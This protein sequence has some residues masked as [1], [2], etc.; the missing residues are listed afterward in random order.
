MMRTPLLAGL[1]CALTLPAAAEHRQSTTTIGYCCK[2]TTSLT[3]CTFAKPGMEDFSLTGHSPRID[4]VWIGQPSYNFGRNTAVGPLI[5]TAEAKTDPDLATALKEYIQELLGYKKPAKKAAPKDVAITAPSG[6]G[7]G[8]AS[9]VI[10]A[11]TGDLSGFLEQRSTWGT[12][13]AKDVTAPLAA[14]APAKLPVT[15]ATPATAKA[16]APIV[17]EAEARPLLEVNEPARAD[18][19][20]AMAALLKERATWG[21]SPNMAKAASSTTESSGGGVSNLT[22]AVT[23]KLS[24]FLALRSTWGTGTAKKVAAPLAAGATAKFPKAEARAAKTTAPDPIVHEAE[25]RPLPQVNEPARAD[26]DKAMAALLKERAT[27]GTSPTT[28]IAAPS[29]SSSAGEISAV[30]TGDLAALLKQRESWGTGSNAAPTASAQANAPTNLTLLLGAASLGDYLS[31][32]DS[33]G[34]GPAAKAVA[35]PLAAGAPKSIALSSKGLSKAGP[36][37][38]TIVHPFV[39]SQP[40][41]LQQV[42]QA[43]LVR[44]RNSLFKERDSW[45]TKPSLSGFKAA[46]NLADYLKRRDRWGTGPKAKVVRAPLANGARKKLR[47]AKSKV[48]ASDSKPPIVHNFASRPLPVVGAIAPEKIKSALAG[49]FTERDSWGTEPVESAPRFAG[50]LKRY[51][52]RRE[53]WG[54]GP[55]AKVVKA[56]LANGAPRKLRLAKSRVSV[57][58]AKPPIVHEL[59]ATPLPV[60]AAISPD[61][62]SGALNDL[63][64]ERQGWGTEPHY[65]EPIVAGDLQAYF[66]RRDRWGTGPKAKVVRAPLAKGA[67]KKLRLAKSK[68]PAGNANPPIVHNFASTPLP[69][70]GAI[71]PEKIK[72]ALAGLFT[73]REGWGTAPKISGA[74][75]AGDLKRYFARR[76]GWGKGP[77]AKTVRA[78]RA[79]GAPRRLRLAKARPAVGTGKPP[80]VHEAEDRPLPQLTA[81]PQNDV[82]SALKAL[83]AER[84]S[85]G[86]APTLAT[87]SPASAATAAP[88]TANSTLE[89]YLAGRDAWNSPGSA[90]SEKK[91]AAVANTATVTDADRGRCSGDLA[92]LASQRKILFEN[93]S[94]NLDA[95]SNT[96]LDKIVETIGGCGQMK[97]SIEGHTD[98]KGSAGFNERLSQARANSVLEYL[99]KAG[100]DRSRLTAKGYGESKPIASNK[101]RKSRALNRRIEFKIK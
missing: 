19:D 81:V 23:G 71:A 83:F 3:P 95:A 55:K 41:K 101:T 43:D 36:T 74:V 35:A 100:I 45:G 61:K 54:T 62:I 50:D 14:G 49:L 8:G 28:A 66:A 92:K 34:K 17:H 20:K 16:P 29:G 79:N 27:W 67:R 1:I 57:G 69:V 40:P 18:I 68:V 24:D 15:A 5:R 32:R 52:S 59:V 96:V 89:T 91:V 13:T 53:A 21:T 7:D 22:T 46:S 90:A 72:S 48:P 85:W 51:F 99:A 88:T 98:S 44:A 39:A 42:S 76:D 4:A 75:F 77:K 12:G 9:D 97:V 94:S 84:S 63:L 93:A 25:A 86:S 64:S 30:G 26:I 78:P 31:T 70:V 56:P 6:F 65:T 47:L 80:I 33:W 58:K 38:T 10:A 82:T 37:S 11:K 73:E 60:V 2:T 87:A